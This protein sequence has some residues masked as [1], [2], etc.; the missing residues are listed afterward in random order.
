MTWTSL[1]SLRRGGLVAGLIAISP[2]VASSQQAD[3]RL[4]PDAPRDRPV[5]TAQRCI[6][7]AMDRAMQ[8]YIARA[9]ASWPQARQRFLA[10]LPARQSF[11]VTALLIDDADR[12]EQVFIAVDTIRDGRISGKIWNR[13]DVVHGFRLGDRYSFPESDLRDWLIT[14]PDGG[15]EGNY[16]GKFLDGYEPPRSCFTNTVGE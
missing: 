2:V 13:V 12:R 15:E 14:K 7:N 3:P 9:R 1:L 4:S 5:L 8:P 6:W 11:F 10:G 16:V